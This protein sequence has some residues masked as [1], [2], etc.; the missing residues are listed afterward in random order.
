MRI[1]DW[2]S[3]VCSSDLII[4]SIAHRRCVQDIIFVRILRHQYFQ[5][6]Q[7]FAYLLLI[8]L[9]VLCIK[10]KDSC[11]QNQ[12]QK[13]PTNKRYKAQVDRKR[14]GE[15]KSIQVRVNSG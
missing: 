15:G 1:S 8:H 2:S 10:D 14:V 7:P 11:E 4:D 5:I 9:K 12:V 6:F 3:D 13:R